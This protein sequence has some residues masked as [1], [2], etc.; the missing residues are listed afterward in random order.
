M[1]ILRR[2]AKSLDMVR[3]C[4]DCSRLRTECARLRDTVELLARRLCA[5]SG[6]NPSAMLH[7]H[8]MWVQFVPEEE[9]LR[10]RQ[11]REERR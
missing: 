10:W 4:P 11:G 3:S 5:V 1:K 6:K 2:P 7:G 9:R 8:P